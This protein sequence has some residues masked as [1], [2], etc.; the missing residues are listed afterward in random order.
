M[1][2]FLYNA[3]KTAR[4]FDQEVRTRDPPR[5]GKAVRQ[6]GGAGLPHKTTYIKRGYCFTKSRGLLLYQSPKPPKELLLHYIIVDA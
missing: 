2:L 3:T 1:E 6:K 5:R 4:R